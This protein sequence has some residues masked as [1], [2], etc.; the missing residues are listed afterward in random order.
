MKAGANPKALDNQRYDIITIAAVKDD[1]AFM[2]L[3]I[4]LGGDPQRDHQPL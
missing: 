2:R 4:S 1:P 3:A